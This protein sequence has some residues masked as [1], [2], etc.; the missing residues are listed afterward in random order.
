MPQLP[1]ANQFGFVLLLG[2]NAED[3]SVTDALGTQLLEQRIGAVRCR[4]HFTAPKGHP[5][6]LKP[7][8]YLG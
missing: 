6:P 8:E 4:N 7:S 2:G 3:A 5:L 1:K